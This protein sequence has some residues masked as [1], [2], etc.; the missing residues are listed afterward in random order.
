MNGLRKLGRWIDRNAYDIEHG[1][2]TV[3]LAAIFLIALII[4]K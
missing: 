4:L 2:L 3:V 1:G